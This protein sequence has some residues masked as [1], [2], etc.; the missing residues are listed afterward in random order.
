MGGEV[1][2]ENEMIWTLYGISTEGLMISDPLWYATGPNWSLVSTCT[3][4]KYLGCNMWSKWENQIL[5]C[6]HST[7]NL[8]NSE[9]PDEMPHNVAFHQGLHCLQR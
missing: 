9:Y 6:F 2:H 5:I 3:L 4:Y 8:A 1:L 7:D